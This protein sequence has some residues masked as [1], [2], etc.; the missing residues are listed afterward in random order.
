[1]RP[2]QLLSIPAGLPCVLEA[3]RAGHITASHP[4]QVPTEEA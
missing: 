3:L 2:E 4:G 1:M